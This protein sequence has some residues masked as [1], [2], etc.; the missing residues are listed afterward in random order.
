[1]NA[2]AEFAVGQHVRLRPD[3]A[4]FWPRR[5]YARRGIVVDLAFGPELVLVRWRGYP[6]AMHMQ[7]A[8]IEEAI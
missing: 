8:D 1:M 6:S 7:A 3:C 5:M 2:A 4:P